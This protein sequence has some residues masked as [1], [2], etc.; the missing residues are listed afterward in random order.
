MPFLITQ[1]VR[2]ADSTD[3]WEVVTEVGFVDAK[4]AEEAFAA[5][6][7]DAVVSDDDRFD[8]PGTFYDNRVTVTYIK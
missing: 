3:D 6:A 2:R 1:E 5:V 8:G 4:E 7:A